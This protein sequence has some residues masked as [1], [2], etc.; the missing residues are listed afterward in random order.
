NL[1]RIVKLASNEN[2]YGYSKRVT[3][4]LKTMA[5]DFEMYPDGYASELRNKIASTLNV[6]E[7]QLVFGAGSDGIITFICRAFL[8]GR[9][10]TVAA[11]PACSPYRQQA[12]IVG[13]VLKEVPTVQGHHDV[14]GMLE[15][16]DNQTKIVWLA[17]PD[18]PTGTV[19]PEQDFHM[20]ME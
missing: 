6:S 14:R 10:I 11:A 17:M 7:E 16:S 8:S 3:E 19:I 9:T 18:N 5:T 1:D 12:L 20:F 4:E 2:P 15:D 13:A